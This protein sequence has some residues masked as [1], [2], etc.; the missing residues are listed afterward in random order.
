MIWKVPMESL[1]DYQNSKI[2]KSIIFFF[3]FL[4][5]QH[6]REKILI[7]TNPNYT[8]VIQK[9]LYNTSI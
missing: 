7:S 1:D 5:N 4:I 6:M 9:Y 3:Q 8:P 2:E